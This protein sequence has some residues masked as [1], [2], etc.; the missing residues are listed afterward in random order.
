MMHFSDWGKKEVRW[1]MQQ[2]AIRLVS[3]NPSQLSASSLANLIRKYEA[4]VM[5]E[6]NNNESKDVS[7]DQLIVALT[8]IEDNCTLLKF[9]VPYALSAFALFVSSIPLSD[10]SRLATATKSSRDFI[11]EVFTI[12]KTYDTTAELIQI[13]DNDQEIIS[14]VSRDDINR[15]S[16]YTYN[17]TTT[18]YGEITMVGGKQIPKVRITLE[19]GHTISCSLINRD[20]VYQ[21]AN[22]LYKRVSATGT[23]SYMR[24]NGESQV[25]DFKIDSIHEFKPL[26]PTALIKKLSPLVKTQI[27]RIDD[28]E[29]FFAKLR[30]D[31]E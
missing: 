17:S 29:G 4:A 21:A 8:S 1:K 20:T 14:T 26:K 25:L 15:I 10:Y 30:G 6:Y 5:S 19:D 24:V 23:A 18:L 2:Y 16:K 9:C 27:S 28:I 12:N 31:G 3:I 22:L 13:K 7:N 11:Q